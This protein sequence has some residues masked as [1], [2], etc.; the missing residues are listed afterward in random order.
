MTRKLNCRLVIVLLAGLLLPCISAQASD[1]NLIAQWT[2]DEDAG[3]MAYDSVGG[4]HGTLLGNPIWTAGQVEGALSFD[5]LDDYV[6]LSSTIQFD[7]KDFT[8]AGWFRTAS[9]TIGTYEQIWMSGYQT[10][11]AEDLEV[12]MKNNELYFYARQAS[13][14]YMRQ[15]AGTAND[16]IWHHF[17]ALRSGN[18]FLLYFDGVLASS[19]S[20]TLG[21]LDEPGV[22]P[23][24]GN[25][26][27]T[28]TD[29]FFNGSIDD[30]R[31][32]DRA[33]TAEEI[34]QL[35]WQGIGALE[36]AVY[37]LTDAVAEK[38]ALLEIIDETMEKEYQA[39]AALEE[40]L[41]T[42]DYD[43]LNKSDIVK[44]KQKI[45]SAIQ[46]QQQ[47]LNALEKSIEK[48]ED[49]LSA[50]GY[51]PEPTDTDN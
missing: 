34:E 49:S 18:N 23:R 45:H 43:D 2:F 1:T 10:V 28:A 42:G 22:V 27:Y 3:M 31:I 17:T 40:A 38:Q 20:K 33:L 29:R 9:N 8:I 16:G 36:F 6:D 24:I 12:V 46:H 5:G 47:S 35:Y 37:C 21:D 51:T 11:G 19:A 32:Y 50:L 7:N 48:L 13:G 26:I 41:D 30:I 4:N 39:Y 44:A 25:G 14:S 15:S